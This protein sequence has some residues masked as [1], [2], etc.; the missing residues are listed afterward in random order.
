MLIVSN[1]FEVK[2]SEGKSFVSLELSGGLEMVQSQT[3]GRYY[4][5]ARTCRIPSTYSLEVAKRMVGTSIE[6]E[7]VRVE[8]KP[9][10]YIV[11]ATGEL[12]K[13]AHSYVYRPLGSIEIHRESKLQDLRTA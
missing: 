4:A 13:L 11:P 10:D 3:T 6:G 7:I 8:V 12:I 2:T 9:Y 1:Y 5:T